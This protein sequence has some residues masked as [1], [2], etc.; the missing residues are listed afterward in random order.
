[1]RAKSCFHPP[2]AASRRAFILTLSKI[3][4]FSWQVYGNRIHSTT[5][6]FWEAYSSW[7]HVCIGRIGVTF[8]SLL[9]SHSLAQVRYGSNM[10]RSA[11]DTANITQSDVSSKIP[12]RRVFTFECV[13]YI[14]SHSLACH[15][16]W[17]HHIGGVIS[18]PDGVINMHDQ[19]LSP[20]QTNRVA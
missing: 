5:S 13:E 1:M 12:S 11:Y 9:S 17:P 20:T 7:V 16:R 3:S 19:R 2:R 8:I 4:I 6:N 10:I 18:C 15:E 14:L